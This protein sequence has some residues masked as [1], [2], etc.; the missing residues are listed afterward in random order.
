MLSMTHFCS[1]NSSSNFS[2]ES[3]RLGISNTNKNSHATRDENEEIKV[4]EASPFEFIEIPGLPKITIG[5]NVPSSSPWTPRDISVF[6]HE[7]DL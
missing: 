6:S 7:V 1:F 5:H 3:F 2:N 4:S